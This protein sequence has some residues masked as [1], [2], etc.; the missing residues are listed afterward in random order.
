MRRALVCVS[1][2]AFSVGFPGVYMWGFNLGRSLDHLHDIEVIEHAFV[3]ALYHD[4][5]T[6]YRSY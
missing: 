4:T 2:A 6:P 5:L 1:S 3:F